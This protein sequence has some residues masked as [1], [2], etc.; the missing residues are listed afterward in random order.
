MQVLT[1]EKENRRAEIE[2]FCI[3][4][5]G[6]MLFIGAAAC[7]GLLLGKADIRVPVSILVEDSIEELCDPEGGQE[8]D[9]ELAR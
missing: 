5:F 8:N 9:D 2:G 4:I 7:F 6:A 1:V 3:A